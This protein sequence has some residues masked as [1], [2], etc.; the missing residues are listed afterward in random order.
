MLEIRPRGSKRIPHP[1]AKDDRP[2]LVGQ[3]ATPYAGQR[4]ISLVRRKAPGATVAVQ[5][6]VAVAVVQARDCGSARRNP[7]VGVAH[8]SAVQDLNRRLLR[9]SRMLSSE[10][11]TVLME[12]RGEGRVRRDAATFIITV[13]DFP[14]AKP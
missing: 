4:N 14:K 11:V 7:L 10:C 1:A 13:Q 5:L 6:H 8:S 2:V 9:I 12:Q 3:N